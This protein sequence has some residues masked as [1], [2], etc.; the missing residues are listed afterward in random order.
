MKKTALA[1]GIFVLWM[2]LTLPVFAEVTGT[3]R[4][5]L[6]QGDVIVQTADTGNDWVAASINMPLMPGDKVWV[7]KSGRAEIQFLGGTYLR[8]D[9]NTEM[10]ITN[11][12]REGEDNIVQVGIPQGRAYVKYGRL[13]SKNSVFQI[14]TPLAS[15]VTYGSAE[16]DVNAY[17]SESISGKTGYQAC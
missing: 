11:L 10:D 6:L 14:D 5:S 2:I 17:E 15:A 3:A 1:A 12:R 9:S 7:P 16:F 13:P 4:L 8:A